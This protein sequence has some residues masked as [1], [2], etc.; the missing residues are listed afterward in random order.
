M[1][2]SIRIGA[3]SAIVGCFPERLLVVLFCALL[4][5][6]LPSDALAD[7]FLIQLTG[8]PYNASDNRPFVLINVQA[9]APTGAFPTT[10]LVDT[11]SALGWAFDTTGTFTKASDFLQNGV[12]LNVRGVGGGQAGTKGATGKP[13]FSILGFRGIIVPPAQTAQQPTPPATFE[14]LPLPRPGQGSIGSA[15]LNT[16]ASYQV[17]NNAGK[18]SRLLLTTT[19]PVGYGGPIGAQSEAVAFVPP[20]TLPDGSIDFNTGG[21]SA[22]VQVS[23]MGS[24]PVKENFIIDSGAEQSLITTSLAAQLGLDLD[25]LSMGTYST[26]LGMFSAPY[27]SLSFSLFPNDPTF[28]Q[29]VSAD[30]TIAN[31]T[32]DPDGINIL[33]SDI[34]SQLAYWE[35]DPGSSTGMFYAAAVPEPSAAALLGVAAVVLLLAANRQRI[36]RSFQPRIARF[37]SA[38]GDSVSL[39]T[40]PRN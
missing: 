20:K 24:S 30:V 29:L 23:A 16:F 10:M 31:P 12:P 38:R 25:S 18:P 14:T 26:D 4:G 3:R 1:K 6:S 33:G 22:T 17:I 15:Y 36:A 7:S 21:F 9:P 5:V 34:L 13:G 19:N 11:G 32:N 37:R 8:N 2:D 28:G 39:S 27:T 40:A 35:I